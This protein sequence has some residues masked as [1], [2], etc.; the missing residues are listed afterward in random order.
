MSTTETA[1]ESLEKAGPN[2]RNLAS[3]AGKTIKKF[4][5]SVGEHL[6]VHNA[7]ELAE[8]V[9]AQ[10][11]KAY[12]TARSTVQERPAMA[13]GIAAGTGLLIGLMLARR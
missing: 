4:A 10:T 3:N 5:D 13:V 9:D 1:F 6:G 12:S 7:G 8:K 11:R 2:G